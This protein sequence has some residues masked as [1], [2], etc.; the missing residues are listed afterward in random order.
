MLA[1][2]NGAFDNVPTVNVSEAENALRKNVKENQGSICSQIENGNKL[3]DEN[4]KVL[5]D[6]AVKASAQFS[7]LTEDGNS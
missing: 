2:T 4:R 6:E 3:T 7:E 5:L 1:V